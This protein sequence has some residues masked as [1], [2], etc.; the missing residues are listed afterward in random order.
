MYQQL[1]FPKKKTK[2][3]NNSHQASSTPTVALVFACSLDRAKA[4]AVCR[5]TTDPALA[6][7]KL[8]LVDS[9]NSRATYSATILGATKVGALTLDSPNNY[10][11]GQSCVALWMS[12]VTILL[13]RDNAST[14][15]N[16][17]NINTWLAKL[18]ISDTVLLTGSLTFSVT[19]TPNAIPI[20]FSAIFFPS[21][22]QAARVIISECA[23]CLAEP[24]VR[25]LSPRL[26]SLP[27]LA[28]LTKWFNFAER[29][30]AATTL[31]V[32][33]TA[34]QD[35][36]TTFQG[37]QCSP[38]TLQLTQMPFLTSLNGLGGVNS[39]LRPGPYVTVSGNPLLQNGASVAALLA[40]AG[41]SAGG[42]AS[43]LS[44]EIFISTT[45]CTSTVRP[46][47]C[48]PPGAPM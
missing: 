6:K 13:R 44:S 40:L 41:C 43:V 39:T 8:L 1:S 21:L 16:P 34:F 35:F 47:F 25:P 18:G 27:G 22:Q 42:S 19:H 46:P 2:K 20:S 12:N 45:A 9:G 10:L 24:T 15:F 14:I 23:D 28:Q 26:R 30:S 4:V 48:S 32:R 17:F 7:D 37:L 38:G 33:G 5:T 11:Y 29:N 31:V 3:Q 36:L